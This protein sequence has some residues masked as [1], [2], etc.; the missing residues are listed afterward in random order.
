MET[1][2]LHTI[3]GIFEPTFERSIE[4]GIVLKKYCER[5]IL[6]SSYLTSKKS[7]KEVNSNW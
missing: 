4:R 2:K 5:N 3:C 1:S 6:L 7:Q